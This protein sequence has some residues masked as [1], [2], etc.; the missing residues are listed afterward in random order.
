MS[1]Q[2]VIKDLQKTSPSTT[3]TTITVAEIVVIAPVL[4]M[5]FIP[6]WLRILII[7]VAL[8]TAG[9]RYWRKKRKSRE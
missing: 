4:G 7:T 6:E 2:D 5:D 3:L 8:G 9:F 1:K